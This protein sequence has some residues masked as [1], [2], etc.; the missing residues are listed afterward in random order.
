MFYFRVWQPFTSEFGNRWNGDGGR[1][2]QDYRDLG[3]ISRDVHVLAH[4]TQFWVLSRDICRKSSYRWTSAA[5]QA[6]PPPST[7]APAARSGP[8]VRVG[9][10]PTHHRSSPRTDARVDLAILAPRGNRNARC[11]RKQKPPKHS[12]PQLAP[13]TPPRIPPD[14]RHSQASSDL[15]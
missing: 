13:T 5:R 6:P 4:P 1:G 10:W 7:S 8:R 9:L 14:C 12:R 3:K 11:A 15:P 2:Q